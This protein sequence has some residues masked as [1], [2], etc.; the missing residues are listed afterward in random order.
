M[1][2]RNFVPEV[3]SQ[4]IL[5][6]LR[7]KTVF[8]QGCH[9]EFTGEIT[10][11]GESIKFAGL[12]DPTVHTIAFADRN[13]AI[14]A[15]EELQDSILEMPIRQIRAVN[16]MVG[17]IDQA[18]ARGDLLRIAKESV[19]EVLA[20]SVDTYIAGLHATDD[21]AIKFNNGTAIKVARGE[22]SETQK[23]PLDL[24]DDLV[25]ALS[26]N[27][28]AQSTPLEMIVSPKFYKL[29]K[30][31]YRDLDTDNSQLMSSGRVGRYNRVVIKQSTN[32]SVSGSTQFLLI[33]TPRYMGY[34]DALNNVEPYRHPD[35]FGDFIKALH[36]FDAK[37][38]RPKEGFYVPVTMA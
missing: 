27:N 35:Y 9:N 3:L 23:N 22:S 19:P 34:A 11:A 1:S 6:E 14:P 2:Y 31:E 13:K 5:K 36:L 8:A 38:I 30:Q 7:A 28:V 15:P 32:I 26:Y 17:D 33:R 4:T 29:C 24:I 20:D 18:Q 16:F 25:E 12:G 21:D 37:V 10:K